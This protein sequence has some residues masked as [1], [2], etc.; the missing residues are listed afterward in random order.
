MPAILT[1]QETIEEVSRVVEDPGS[2]LEEFIES[3][4]L[5]ADEEATVKRSI[6]ALPDRAVEL[7]A[8]PKNPPSVMAHNWW[9]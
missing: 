9:H 4:S 3:L 7:A 8:L 2:S 6:Q 1:E 5:P